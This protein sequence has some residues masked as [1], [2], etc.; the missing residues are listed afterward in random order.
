MRWDRRIDE[1]LSAVENR[2][3]RQGL[4]GPILNLKVLPAR[5]SLYQPDRYDQTDKQKPS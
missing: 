2:E 3:D 5:V 1:G 4:V